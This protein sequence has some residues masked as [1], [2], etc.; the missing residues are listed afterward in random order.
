MHVPNAEVRLWPSNVDNGV[1]DTL[2]K[3]FPKVS[4]GQGA[5]AVKTAVAESD[6]LLT[7]TGTY[8]RPVP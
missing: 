6:F 5:E 8:S 4:I 7:T 3:R 1:S 2:K